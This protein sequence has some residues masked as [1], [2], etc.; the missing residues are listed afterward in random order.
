MT[1][2]TP[3]R[4]DVA[5]GIGESTR[6]PDGVPKLRGEFDYIQDL[7]AEGMLWGATVRSPHPRA[8]IVSIDIAPA[9]ALGGVHAVLTAEDV[10][11]RPKFGLEHP[12]QPVLASGEVAYWGE[13]VA[14]VAAEDH[15]TARRA[16]ADYPQ[17]KRPRGEHP[18]ALDAPAK[19]DASRASPGH[20]HLG[21]LIPSGPAPRR[22]RTS[23]RSPQRWQRY[24]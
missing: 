18:A 1:T 6:R 4:V 9:L 20:P 3:A 5:G 10:P 11:G 14:I 2:R 16:A 8:R 13:P 24:S 23:K 15:D 7:S 19:D 22:C 17:V 21:Q 12:D